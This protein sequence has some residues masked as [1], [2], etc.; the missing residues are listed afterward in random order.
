MKFILVCFIMFV[1]IVVFSII[2]VVAYFSKNKMPILFDPEV[3]EYSFR[4]YFISGE[5]IQFVTN[6]ENTSHSTIEVSGIDRTCGC[7]IFEDRDRITFP[8]RLKPG[9]KLPV[10]LDIDTN[11][12]SGLNV[13]GIRAKLETHSSNPRTISASFQL[14]AYIFSTLQ[15]IPNSINQD[16]HRSGINS[17]LHFSIVLADDR[18]WKVV[19]VDRIEF[20]SPDRFRFDLK[21]ID[22]L[23][24]DPQTGSDRTKR[25]SLNIHYIPPDNDDEYEESIKVTTDEPGAKP[26]RIHLTGKI[27]PEFEFHPSKLIFT[28]QKLGMKASRVVEYRYDVEE[29]KEIIPIDIPKCYFVDD[30]SSI[31]GVRVFRIS[32]ISSDLSEYPPSIP[33]LIGNN[34]KVFLPVKVYT[35]SSRSLSR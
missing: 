16:V 25:F 27:V 32:L 30:I 33:F 20:S 28:E 11:G 2:S 23:I 21:P 19:V 24:R 3:K 34:M 4:D 18:P 10:K 12:K 5:R 8:L 15:A 1:A 14:S 22:G 13:F 29:Y 9:E 35:N 7:M 6:L 26:I 31:K 17:E